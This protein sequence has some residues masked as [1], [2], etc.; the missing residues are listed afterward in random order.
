MNLL[1]R[2]LFG[3]AIAA[4]LIG[5]AVA[6]DNITPQGSVNTNFRSKD[7]GASGSPLQVPFQ[8]PS[9]VTGN[10]LF[11]SGNAGVVSIGSN[12][13]AFASTP[14]FNLSQIAGVGLSL[15][16]K[17]G[18]SSIPVVMASDFTQAITASALPLPTGASTAANQNSEITALGLLNT[19]NGTPGD[20][21]YSGSNTASEI[22]LLK[23]IYGQAPQ[24]TAPGGTHTQM[25]G[26]EGS[27]GM[28]PV[29][30]SGTVTTQAGVSMVSPAY[31]IGS[32]A[33]GNNAQ[34]FA[35]GAKKMLHVFFCNKATADRVYKFYDTASV[36][37]PGTTAI[38]TSIYA[39][40][41]SCPAI[42]FSGGGFP[43][44][45]GLAGAITAAGDSDTG[46]SVAAGDIV[47]LNIEHN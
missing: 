33:S 11:T 10:P 32:S 47:G 46:S 20:A 15:G 9:D 36:P 16:Q 45:S 18:A 24:T 26:V 42:D 23:A 44:A 22:A 30:V 7:I 29:V 17:V 31:R 3:A 41:G 39:P 35:T 13:P 25:I 14:A 1:A 27:T 12:L 38:V 19:A 8:I 40:A 6:A 37:T 28:T 2:S 43:F 4:A 21:A 34:V 5:P